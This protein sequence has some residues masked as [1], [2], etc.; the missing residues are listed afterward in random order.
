VTPSKTL[1]F[2][3]AD[4]GAKAA[5]PRVQSVARAIA[6]LAAVADSPG[7]LRAMEI[8]ARLGLGRQGTYH[9]LH[10]LV[11]CGMLARN[12][13][14]RYVLGLQI[15]TLAD[16]FTRQLA[17]PEHLA[18]L[19]RQVAVETGETAYAVGWRDGEIVNLVSAPGSNAIQATTV[20]QGY[21]RFAHARATGKL[22]LAYAAPEVREAYLSDHA[23]ERRTPKTLV[24]RSALEAE[25][26]RIQEDGFATD[27]EEFALGLCCLAVP[28]GRGATFAIGISAPVERFNAEFDGYLDTLRRVAQAA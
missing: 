17:P 24:A 9:L 11:G 10:T 28:V 16:A 4:A 25:L 2:R 1:A 18:P 14:N 3:P 20:P 15:A 22:L 23:M 12:Q 26:T 8:A 27:R 5:Q 19:V 6:I 21:Y 13:E 7:G